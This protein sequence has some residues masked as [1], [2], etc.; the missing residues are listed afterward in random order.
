MLFIDKTQKVVDT[1]TVLTVKW[2]KEVDI[3]GAL[4]LDSRAV[5]AVLLCHLH[6]DEVVG[7]VAQDPA[8]DEGSLPGGGELVLAGCPLDQPKHHVP[9]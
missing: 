3:P 5:L 9:S 1:H 8:D 7:V 6:V 2:A 4:R